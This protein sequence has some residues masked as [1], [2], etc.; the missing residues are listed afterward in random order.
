MARILVVDD[1]ESLRTIMG[2]ILSSHGHSPILCRSVKE[3]MDA[4][5]SGRIDLAISDIRMEPVNGM[6]LLKEIRSIQPGTPVIMMTAYASVETALDALKI[7]AYDYLTKPFKIVD[8]IA[9]VEKA[10]ASAGESDGLTEA[11]GIVGARYCFGR[12]VGMS[13]V[14]AEAC[15]LLELVAPTDATVLLHGE[16]GSGRSLIAHTVHE[17][18]LR[19]GSICA[20]IDC[21][22]MSAGEPGG[23]A[24]S[25]AHLFAML[26]ESSGGTVVL[27]NVECLP[28]GG[29]KLILSLLRDKSI[30]EEG[31]KE[32]VHLDVRIIATAGPC[33]RKRV[34]SGQFEEDL[35]R[36]LGLLSVEIKPLC[37]RQEDIL[38]LFIHFLQQESGEGEHAIPEVSADVR[39]ALQH[40]VW[41]GNV[42]EMRDVVKFAMLHKVNG[43]VVRQSLP[44]EMLRTLT[45]SEH[46]GSVPTMDGNRAASL[47]AFLRKKG[48]ELT[49]AMLR[50]NSGD[51]K[52]A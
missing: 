39:G 42:A 25:V 16:K 27:Q 18:S 5:A 26:R 21:G 11:N 40:Y 19:A 38:P 45:V 31:R 10:L 6:A 2:Q 41:P 12:V 35:Y 3:A 30:V 33:L 14:M 44:P 48:V 49:D 15:R 37:E 28:P 23:G 22:K 8:F 7:G 32:P 9:V 52:G 29:Q 17:K 43:A 1:E 13:A 46:I 4:L 34:E 50:R 20:S 51:A 47:K 24:A 36:R